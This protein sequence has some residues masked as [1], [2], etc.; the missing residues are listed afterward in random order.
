VQRELALADE[1]VAER[2]RVA[3][4]DLL[5]RRVRH[6]ARPLERVEPHHGGERL[7][8]VARV[9]PIARP[10]DEAERLG[11]CARRKRLGLM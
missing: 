3:F 2:L 5:E 1:V 8:L 9:E 6:L 7:A 11:I 10:H 4:E